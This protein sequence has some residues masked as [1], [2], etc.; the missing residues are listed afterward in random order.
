MKKNFIILVVML[1]SF[2]T[3]FADGRKFDEH[4]NL[5]GVDRNEMNGAFYSATLHYI[6]KDNLYLSG[7]TPDN[8]FLFITD[9]EESYLIPNETISE[10]YWKYPIE[11]S[12][13]SVL[14]DEDIAFTIMLINELKDGNCYKAKTTYALFDNYKEAIERGEDA[15][16]IP[17]PTTAI[18]AS[19]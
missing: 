6:S 13:L 10:V 17:A 19:K 5:N 16:Y 3:A 8:L 18:A 7:K 2:A 11:I 14:I 4:G 15:K 9:G 1:V 12:E